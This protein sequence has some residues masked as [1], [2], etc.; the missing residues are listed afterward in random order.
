LQ[1]DLEIPKPAP[2]VWKGWPTIG[3]GAAIFI[4]YSIVQAIILLIVHIFTTGVGTEFNVQQFTESLTND[5]LALAISTIVSA[6]VGILLIIV[7]IK[8][9]RGLSITEYLGFKPISR[10]TILIAVS[11]PIVLTVLFEL[12]ANFFIGDQSGGFMVDAYKNTSFPA[13]FWIAMVVFAPAFEEALFRGFLFIGLKE[14]RVGSIGA[15]IITA[16]IWAVLHIQYDPT[17]MVVIFALGIVMGVVRLKTGSI[18]S[19]FLIHVTWNLLAMVGTVLY[20]NGIGN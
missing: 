10:K 2:Q 14:S 1:A 4:I 9:R 20:L 6:L 16:M 12:L 13:L 11:I 17:I 5:G 8:A 15:I 7:F 19:T 18:K 3:L